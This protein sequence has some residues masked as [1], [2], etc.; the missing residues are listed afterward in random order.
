VLKAIREHD[1]AP[2]LL[3]LELTESSL[4]SNA[5]E[6]ITVLQHLKALGIRFPSTTSA[7]AIPR[8]PI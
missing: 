4:M 3:E 7:P 8:W 5:E 2:E 6:T 1:I